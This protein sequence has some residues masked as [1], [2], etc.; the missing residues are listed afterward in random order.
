MKKMLSKKYLII[1]SLMLI[2]L[3]FTHLPISY[4]TQTPS[5][6][7]VLVFLSDVVQLDMTKYNATLA[8]G[9][10]VK[11]REDL[12]GLINVYGKYALKSE[13]SEINVVFDFI[14]N[15]LCSC[16]LYFIKGVPQYSQPMKSN[17]ADEART[18]I[19]RYQ[20]FTKDS[21]LS[22]MYQMLDD[23]D[24][25]KNSTIPDTNLSLDIAVT[26]YATSL[27]W[28]KTFSGAA[29]S[30]LT[31]GFQNGYFYLFGE[32]M[33]YMSIGSTEVNFSKEKVISMA[34]ERA[35]GYSYTYGSQQ[36]SNLTIATSNIWA[37]L[38]TGYK[39]KPLVLYPYWKVTLPLNGYYP[40]FVTMII[41]EFWADTGE[42]IKIYPLG[43]GGGPAP[44]DSPSPVPSGSVQPSQSP[45][46]SP[47]PAAS[48]SPAPSASVTL[49]PSQSSMPTLVPSST[50]QYSASPSLQPADNIEARIPDYGLLVGV[51]V[52]VAVVVGAVLVAFVVRKRKLK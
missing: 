13:T 32:D 50:P 36:I 8:I 31:I 27:T 39:D 33:S 44:S 35:S 10:I 49:V 34:L 15:T 3:N 28:K 22:V 12:G 47:S 5:T 16:H 11:V 38:L 21:N 41:V 1:L 37:D 14:N 52:V 20:N 23:V 42:L 18:I 48:A 46:S 17:V 29:F 26:A 25:T 19:Q 4:A 30:S 43:T 45:A 9:P 24:A 2:V 6:D 40:G 7:S 51:F